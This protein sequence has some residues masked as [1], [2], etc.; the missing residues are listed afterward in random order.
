MNRVEDIIIYNFILKFFQP[1]L[2][3]TFGIPDTCGVHNLHGM[4]GVFAGIVGAIMASLATESIYNNET[5]HNI[6]PARATSLY[7]PSIGENRTSGQQALYQIIALVVT[8]ALAIV[9]GLLTG[10]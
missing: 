5:M 4:P 9:A 2:N 10:L 6:Y 7:L 1:L 8:L 3:N